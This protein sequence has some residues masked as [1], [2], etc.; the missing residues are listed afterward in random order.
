M[1]KNIQH[2]YKLFH[3]KFKEFLNYL[4]VIS[5]KEWHKNIYNYSSYLSV[6]L[7]LVT[8]TGVIYINPEYTLFLHNFIIYYVCVILLVRFNPLI[9]KNHLASY[10]E[11][12]RNI[13]FTAGIILLTT[14]VAKR[15]SDIYIAPLKLFYKLE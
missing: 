2:A 7:I 12:N 8:Y 14:S 11:F 10:M 9:K 13:A 5:D 4:V 1:Y 15:V 3:H 6:I